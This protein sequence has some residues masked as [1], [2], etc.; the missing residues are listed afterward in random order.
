MT[1][2]LT[3]ALVWLRYARE[4]LA[5]AQALLGTS[6]V[7]RHPAWLA[8]QAAEK[9]MKALLVAD[10]LPF[11]KTHDLERLSQLLPDPSIV[12]R[13][14]TDLANLT[15][16]A[17]GSRYPGDFP[18]NVTAADAATAVEDAG[19]IVD[20]VGAALEPRAT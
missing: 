15:E 18:D 5:A 19:R 12:Q 16:Y 20:A 1:S 4:D 8:Q 11:P 10:A 2:D 6:V 3:D 14:K 13:T 17:V 7:P 9:A